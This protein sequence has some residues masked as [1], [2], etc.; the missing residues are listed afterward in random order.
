MIAMICLLAG[1]E[2]QS[3]IATVAAFLF[4]GGLIFYTLGWRKCNHSVNKQ[5]LKISLKKRFSSAFIFLLTKIKNL[6]GKTR[7][8]TKPLIFAVILSSLLSW[9][10]IGGCSFL[11]ESILKIE[12]R[13][14]PYRISD[15]QKTLEKYQEKAEQGDAYAQFKVGLAHA[16]GKGIPEDDVTASEWWIKAAEQ[17]EPNAQYSLAR[18]YQNGSGVE[19]DNIKFIEWLEKAVEQNHSYALFTMGIEHRIGGILEKSE[20]KEKEFFTKAL[21]I[22][23][24]EV[25][26][27]DDTA[28]TTLG[29]MLLWGFG[30]DKDVDRALDYL[31]EAAKKRNSHAQYVLGI[32]GKDEH[33][34][35]EWIKKSAEQGHDSAQRKLGSAYYD[36]DQL[37]KDN[38]KAFEWWEK[39]AKQGE[40]IAQF[41]VGVAYQEGFGGV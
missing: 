13:E 10:L 9:L 5:K 29:I 40:S 19:K 32:F 1:A 17:G 6:I 21:D 18:A 33:A 27:G 31:E 15:S 36:G 16:K 14:Y 26:T 24:D 34:R 22:L 38:Q 7:A 28:Q 23:K 12:W 30:V 2:S 35:I 11:E 41:F 39:A 4:L 20:A 8:Y 25:A 3:L 37:P